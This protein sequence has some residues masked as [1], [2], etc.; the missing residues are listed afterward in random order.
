MQPSLILPPEKPQNNGLGHRK[1]SLGDETLTY[2]DLP[3]EDDSI[4]DPAL[5][6]IIADDGSAGDESMDSSEENDVIDDR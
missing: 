2:P 3:M 5:F 1:S 6:L 4:P